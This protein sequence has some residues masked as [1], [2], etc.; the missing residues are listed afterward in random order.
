[1]HESLE[2]ELEIAKRGQALAE[3]KC[4]RLEYACEGV[5]TT[6]TRQLKPLKSDIE[7]LRTFAQSEIGLLGAEVTVTREQTKPTQPMLPTQPTPP[8]LTLLARLP[9]H[10]TLPHTPLSPL[11]P[12]TFLTA[13]PRVRR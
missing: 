12:L 7:R 1:M 13:H 8:T 11:S 9:P 10:P 4:G 2:N 6:V 3:Q 5:K